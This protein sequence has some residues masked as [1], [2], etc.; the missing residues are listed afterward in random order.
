MVAI[1][2]DPDLLVELGQQA[3]RDMPHLLLH[4]GIARLMMSENIRQG[5]VDS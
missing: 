5:Q 2:A 4:E 3:T 1:E